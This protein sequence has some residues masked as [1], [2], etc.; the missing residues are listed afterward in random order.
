VKKTFSVLDGMRGI[1]AIYVLIIHT[2]SF[3]G[4]LDFHHSYLAVDLF[5]VL[6]GFVIA[7]AYENKLD[8]G[9]LSL[10]NFI[11]V[12]LI[13]LYPMY[14]LSIIFAATIFI[15]H[16]LGGRYESLLNTYQLIE[17]IA[18]SLLFLPTYIPG[19][20]Y[21]FPLNIPYWSIFYE[22]IMNV[23]YV[24]TREKLTNNVLLILV[25]SL[26]CL[27]ALMA[28]F[29]GDISAGLTWR[30]TSIVSAL[31]RSGFGIFL[32]VYLFRINK[33]LLINSPISSWV[34]I[35]ITA[36]SLMTPDLG[37]LNGLFDLFAV[38]FIFP[39]L[40]LLGVR[41]KHGPIADLIF[42]KLGVVSYPIYLLHIPVSLIIYLYANNLVEIYAPW[43]G[44]GLVLG[45]II[46]SLLA[47][48]YLDI[49]ARRFLTTRF[50]KPNFKY[51]Q[52][53]AV[54]S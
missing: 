36:L 26:S 27:L 40:V 42:K 45:L 28:Y 31:V 21:L 3:W 37:R 24:F 49:P 15:L 35:L 25:I 19:I 41:S 12:R 34:V 30:L 53:N 11:L 46:L 10:K 44:A 2:G 18:L 32:G 38:T 29:R 23:V 16:Y 20:V 14:F 9:Q 6:S 22:L 54:A 51:N 39:L 5:F 4:N 7:H 43:S 33:S 48:K 47:E 52:K 50:I 8:S 17:L 1:A 13:R